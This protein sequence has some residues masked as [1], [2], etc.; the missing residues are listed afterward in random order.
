MLSGHTSVSKLEIADGMIK[1]KQHRLELLSLVSV[2]LM[3]NTT[4]VIYS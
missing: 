2:S 4:S 1:P 3:E